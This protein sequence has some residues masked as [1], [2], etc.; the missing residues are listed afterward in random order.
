MWLI[1]NNLVWNAADE[2]GGTPA[3]AAEPAPVVDP[4]A[5]VPDAS[6]AL[7]PDDQAPDAAQTDVKTE[8]DATA[9]DTA[10]KDDAAPEWAEYVDDPVKTPEENAAAKLE[11]DLK[12]PINQVP[13]DGVYNLTMPDGVELDTDL[14]A[15]IAPTLKELNMS[16]GNAQA[17]VDKFI[18]GQQAKAE[19]ATKQWGETVTGW[20][21]TAKKDPEM[22]G[23]KW[24]ETARNA[25][26]VVS[27]FGTPELKE[28]LEASGAGNHPEVIRLMAKVGSMIA[29]D[30]PAI[31]ENPGGGTDA[32]ASV[33]MYPADKPKGT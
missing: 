24:D 27:R 20:L 10:V 2:G 30:N 29:E 15:V 22:G 18:E 13:E 32:D 5:P 9:D 17:L 3:P 21:D 4:A 23:A 16:H 19:A 6:S 8:T 28:Y 31:S 26:S 11:N 7:Y 12:H 33:R 25:S 1:K 14:L